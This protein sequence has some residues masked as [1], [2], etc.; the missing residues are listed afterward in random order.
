[1]VAGWAPAAPH[2]NTTLETMSE[3]TE[4]LENISTRTLVGAERGARW[5]RV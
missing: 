2:R 1:V 4:R 5:Q 3:Q